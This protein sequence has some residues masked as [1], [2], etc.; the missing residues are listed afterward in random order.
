MIWDVIIINIGVFKCWLHKEEEGK[1]CQGK[2]EWQLQAERTDGIYT[3]V[4]R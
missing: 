3:Q 2:I 4:A 1:A